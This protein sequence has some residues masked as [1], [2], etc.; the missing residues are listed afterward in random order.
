MLLIKKLAPYLLVLLFSFAWLVYN[1]SL[2]LAPAN[3]G[4]GLLHFFISQVS[5]EDPTFLLNHWGKPLFV[6]LSCTFAQIGYGGMF[7]FNVLV[8]LFTTVFAW[9][10]LKKLKVNPGLALCF[11]FL[12]LLTF[13]YTITVSAGLTE[14]LFSLF[15]V[16]GCWYLLQSSYTSA[17]FIIGCLPFLRSEG[18]LTVLLFLFF[19]IYARQG[20]SILVLALPFLIYS[21]IGW[22][23][24]KD[25]LWF[26][27]HSPYKITNNTYGSGNY[28]HYLL[29]YKNFIGNHGL[30]LFIASIPMIFISFRSKK[31]QFNEFVLVFISFGTFFGIIV[32][33][34]YF[35]G[36][37][38]HGSMGLTRIATQALP[39]FLIVSLYFF[40]QY[41]FLKTK[42]FRLI[43]YLFSFGMLVQLFVTPFLTKEIQPMEESIQRMYL[44]TNHLVKNAN[45]VTSNIYFAELLGRNPLKKR[46][47]QTEILS[48][49]RLVN[50]AF[51][52]PSGTYFLWDNFAGPIELN[53]DFALISTYP[54]MKLVQK[55]QNKGVVV[56]L[57]V[58]DGDQNYL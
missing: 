29:S 44:N 54:K 6:L 18:Q 43:G 7:L 35:W 28:F 33:H 11:P 30:F 42:G 10:I 14:P 1:Q 40:S 34:S 2:L 13:D 26:F 20:K 5:W 39:S 50:G 19:L 36:S 56:C 22:F 32:S 58:F 41:N 23:T 27:S 3:T 53:V 55:I 17:A 49:E 38:T 57:F 21:T 12:L 24:F 47:P 52:F 48:R 8:F 25:F 15:L 37:G 51:S 31:L 4:D 45:L 46:N 9:F 16:V